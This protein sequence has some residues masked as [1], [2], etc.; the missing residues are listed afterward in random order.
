MAATDSLAALPGLLEP[1][2]LAQSLL[3][4]PWFQP[5]MML[6]CVAAATAWLTARWII[7]RR[8]GCAGDCSRCTAHGPETHAA[9][10][11]LSG[12]AQP[13]ACG[14][15]PGGGIRPDGLKV[16]Q[17]RG[18]GSQA[19]RGSGSRTANVPTHTDV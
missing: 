9:G 13:G 5:V 19:P 7:R 6:L 17:N 14:R 11:A 1:L 16:L 10:G 8:S 15:P 18:P 4:Q 3:A 2:L 12:G